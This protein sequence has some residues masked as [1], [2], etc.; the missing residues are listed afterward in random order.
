M[1]FWLSNL[2][3]QEK[4]KDQDWDEDFRYGYNF[5][6]GWKNARETNAYME[7][8]GGRWST[9]EEI[10][11]ILYDDKAYISLSSSR[12]NVQEESY[13]QSRVEESESMDVSCNWTLPKSVGVVM[14]VSRDVPPKVQNILGNVKENFFLYSLTHISPHQIFW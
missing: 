3:E 1:L 7:M 6:I 5:A 2:E 14:V 9:G 8:G 11:S 10:K 4:H 13:L 12:K